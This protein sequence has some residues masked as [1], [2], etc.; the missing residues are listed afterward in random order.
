MANWRLLRLPSAAALY[1]PRSTL[2]NS[3]IGHGAVH[4]TRI[5]PVDA[6]VHAVA[7]VVVVAVGVAIKAATTQLAN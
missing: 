3:I 1:A 4:A 5:R 6:T 7:A 2:A